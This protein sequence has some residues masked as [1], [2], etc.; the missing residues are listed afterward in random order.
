MRVTHAG[1]Y[2]TLRGSARDGV[3]ASG[4]GAGTGTLSGDAPFGMYGFHTGTMWP[5]RRLSSRELHSSG[6]APTT[7]CM[8][9]TRLR[10]VGTE[11]LM[12]E[13]LSASHLAADDE[14][15]EDFMSSVRMC[16]MRSPVLIFTGHF[17]WHMPSAAHVS[18]PSYSYALDMTLRRSVSS[19]DALSSAC[20][21]LSSRYTV[22]RWR[23][24]SVMSLDGQLD[25][26]NPHSMQRLTIGLATG[27]GFRNLT[28]ASGSR[29]ST[30]PG[31]S[32]NCGSN[33]SLSSHMSSYAL[34][35]HS[36]STNGATLRPVPCSPLRLPECLVATM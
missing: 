26:Q 11:P 4:A 20:R 17:S 8:P 18:A 12:S 3:D 19:G 6:A 14:R 24:V 10:N 1:R 35:P 34:L 15:G 32:T 21:R 25:S 31:L 36:I 22:M 33:S 5:V 2:T 30:T 23:G 9:D 29:F 13:K 27:L 28:C 16:L 7:E